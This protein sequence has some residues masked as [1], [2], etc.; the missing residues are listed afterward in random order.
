MNIHFSPTCIHPDRTSP[1]ASIPNATYRELQKEFLHM[2]IT[3]HS[4]SSFSSCA[5][6]PSP[7]LLPFIHHK[8]LNIFLPTVALFLRLSGWFVICGLI[9]MKMYCIFIRDCNCNACPLINCNFNRILLGQLMFYLAWTRLTPA[10]LQKN[11]VLYW[12]HF[13][14]SYLFLFVLLTPPSSQ[15]QYVVDILC[16]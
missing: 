10:L 2:H 15:A 7:L 3:I 9:L 8:L 14:R 13:R 11:T 12:M 6:P 1:G 4:L 5:A 16:K